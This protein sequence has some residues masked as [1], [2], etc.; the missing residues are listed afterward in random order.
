MP[1]NKPIRLDQDQQELLNRYYTAEEASQG[2][3]WFEK[4]GDYLGLSDAR[5]LVPHTRTI[6]DSVT[7][8]KTETPKDWREISAEAIL[9]SEGL[10]LTAY[11]RG[12]EPHLTIGYGHFGP[13]V[14]QGQVWTKEQAMEAF[15]KDF[16]ETRVFLEGLKGFDKLSPWQKA[17]LG[18][19]FY[20]NG[21]NALEAKDKDG[22]KKPLMRAAV[23]KMGR[24]DLSGFVPAF[25]AFHLSDPKDKGNEGVKKRMQ[26][27]IDLWNTKPKTTIE[28]KKVPVDVF[29]YFSLEEKPKTAT[30][31]TKPKK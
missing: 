13:D 30:P 26:R 25:S 15:K 6:Q 23:E 28:T 11:R 8:V 21:I 4:A 5:V 20:Q 18:S 2:L 3:G 24:G 12:K 16:E 17:T 10:E 31:D 27:N 29:D 14:K 7:S 9:P 1:N 22:Y 19:Y